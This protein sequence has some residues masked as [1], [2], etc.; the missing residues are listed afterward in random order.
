MCPFFS[1]S[2]TCQLA[3]SVSSTSKISIA[4]SPSFPFSHYKLQSSPRLTNQ[5]FCSHFLTGLHVLYHQKIDFLHIWLILHQM[6]AQ[7]SLMTPMIFLIQPNTFI[8]WSEF[9]ITQVYY[10]SSLPKSQ[11]QT[12]R[13]IC[14]PNKYCYFHYSVLVCAVFSAC[15]I[16]SVIP[17]WNPCHQSSPKSDGTFYFKSSLNHTSGSPLSLLRWHWHHILGD[18]QS[19]L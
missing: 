2:I 9:F 10:S 1:I 8:W 19:Y 15:K 18:P 4:S 3:D 6:P 11:L 17:N 7:T 14:S 16:F 13:L 5:N 12:Q